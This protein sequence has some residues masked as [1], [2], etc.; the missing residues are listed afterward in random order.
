MTEY[1]IVANSFAAPFVSDT[2][3]TYV[4]ADTPEDALYDFAEDYGHPFGLYS[5]NAYASADDFHKGKE[6]LAR[7]RSNKAQADSVPSNPR[8]GRVVS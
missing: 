4:T 1:F 8:E 6:P 3:N 2:S 5:A 7:W